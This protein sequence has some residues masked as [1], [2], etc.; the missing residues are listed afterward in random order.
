MLP[1][2]GASLVSGGAGLL[3]QHMANTANKDLQ[4]SANSTAIALA[5][6]N[7]QWQEMMSNTAHQR[8]VK[9]LKAAGLNPILS[10]TGGSG[11]SS[12]S[13]SVASIGAAKM[14]DALGKG[15][16]SAMAARSLAADIESKE[17]GNALN[18]AATEAKASEIVSNISSA[19]AADA[20]AQNTAEKTVGEKLA[21]TV[22]KKQMPTIA[23]RADADKATA[24]WDK[25]A[26]TY[27]AIVNRGLN[28]LG[29]A[30]AA[31]GNFFRGRPSVSP[32]MAIQHKAMKNFL[33]DRHMPRK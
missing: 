32:K 4:N 29:G 24:E 2:M 28:L 1:V 27:D 8:Q 15:V 31:F 16:S 5:A 19:K 25:S 17:A 22:T 18:A 6:E 3:G 20:A 14:E 23:A 26:S 10:A 13:G 33:K 11:A 30:S 7:R 9:D 12:P 21:N